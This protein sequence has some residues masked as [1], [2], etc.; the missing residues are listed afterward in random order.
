M[1]K[2][3]QQIRFALRSGTRIKG[4][5]AD[6]VGKTLAEINNKHGLL[7]GQLVVDESRPDEAPLHGCFEWNDE[8]AGE[9]YRVDQARKIIKGV[10]VITEEHPEPQ[11]VYVHVPKDDIAEAA[12]HP[13]EVVVARPDM[14]AAALSQLVGKMKQ[15]QEAVTLLKKAAEQSTDI[16]PERMARIAMAVQ[17]L[18][19]ASA[20]VQALH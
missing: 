16:E 14:Y 17:A 9:L 15:A 7:T 5:D 11:A 4:A 19:T 20:A 18:A 13:V 6:T 3:S 1:S 2:K 8:V 12:Y 10:Q